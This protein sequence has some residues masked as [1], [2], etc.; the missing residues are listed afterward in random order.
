VA[1][2][3]AAIAVHGFVDSFF[4][5]T[6]TYVLFAVTLGLA[7]ACDGLAAAHANRV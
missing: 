3:G 2:A 1:A 5:F 4:S 6:A 7:V